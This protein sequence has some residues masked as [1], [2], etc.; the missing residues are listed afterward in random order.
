[1]SSKRF[2]CSLILI[3]PVLLFVGDLVLG[4]EKIVGALTVKDGLTTPRQSVRIEAR[5]IRSGL[6]VDTGLGGEPLKLVIDGKSVA[7]AMTGGDGR[8]FFDYL[9]KM[10]GVYEFT[11]RLGTTPRVTATETSGTLA[12]WEKRRP[13]LLVDMAALLEEAKSSPLPLPSLPA[14]GGAQGQV[15]PIPGAA[16]ELSRLTQFY[17]NVIY[18]SWP[19]A[20]GAAFHG[21]DSI[22]T[23]LK[24]H[25]FPTGFVVAVKPGADA[26][27]AV[28]DEFKKEGWTTLKI[29]IVRSRELANVL[30]EHRMEAILVPEPAR[31]EVPKKAKVAKDWKEVRKKL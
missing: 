5:L 21:D 27:G 29:G 30:L 16:D 22:R 2:V 9:P 31:G 10:R 24:E 19:G 8:A 20:E 7:T 18:L 12:V 25:K 28:L 23:W 11:V 17:Y 6:L 4:A 26:L 15:K 1:M 3:L 14:V 13:V